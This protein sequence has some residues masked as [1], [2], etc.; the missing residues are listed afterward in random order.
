MIESVSLPKGGAKVPPSLASP[1]V[2]L[3]KIEKNFGSHQALRGVDLDIY[4]V[5]RLDW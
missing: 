2:S 3:R 4:P 5:S 1:L